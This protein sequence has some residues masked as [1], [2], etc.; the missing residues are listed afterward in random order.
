MPPVII[1]ALGAFGAGVAI[2]W[3]A[4]EARRLHAE[5]HRHESGELGDEEV[6]TLV[7]DPVTGIYRP[8]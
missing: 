7:Q 3:I 2:R 1:L 4:R 6:R 8:K 5:L